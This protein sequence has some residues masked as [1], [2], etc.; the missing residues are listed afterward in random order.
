MAQTKQ[1]RTAFPWSSA[2]LAALLLVGGVYLL[3]AD[4]PPVALSWETASEVGAAGFNVYRAEVPGG[5]F[6]QVNTALIPAEGDEIGGA[7]YRFE[8]DAV[9]PGRRYAYRIEEV[10]WNG[11]ATLHPETVTARAGLPRAW[12]KAEGALLLAL[13]AILLWRAF[14]R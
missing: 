14:K 7:A 4:I 3:L 9:K 2:A 10:E 8:D 11:A 13:G 6:V 1:A 5:D 12:T